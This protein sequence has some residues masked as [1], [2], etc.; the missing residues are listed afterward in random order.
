MSHKK[1]LQLFDKC[2]ACPYPLIDQLHTLAKYV[3]VTNWCDK[4]PLK[5][6]GAMMKILSLM[7]DVKRVINKR[8]SFTD[9]NCV[10]TYLL[11]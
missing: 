1:Q 9:R 10:A 8:F 2:E 5:D 6:F 4:T 11:V 7:I 3:F